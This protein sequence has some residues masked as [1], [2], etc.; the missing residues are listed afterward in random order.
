MSSLNSAS[1]AG[2]AS[3]GEGL[4]RDQPAGGSGERVSGCGQMRYRRTGAHLTLTS[5]SPYPGCGLS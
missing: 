1:A 3:A 5:W 2:I 4:M